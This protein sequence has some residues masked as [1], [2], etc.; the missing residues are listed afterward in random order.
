MLERSKVAFRSILCRTS[1]IEIDRRLLPGESIEKVWEYCGTILDQFRS[2]TPGFDVRMEPP[3]LVDEAWTTDPKEESVL[4]AGKVL[5]ALG[6]NSTP[7]GVP[8]GS[9]ASK[10]ARAGIPSILLQPGEHRPT[11]CRRR[12]Y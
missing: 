1:A 9:D 12:V 11:P 8:F 6:L 5:D 4:V 3:M 2:S 7:C 10:F